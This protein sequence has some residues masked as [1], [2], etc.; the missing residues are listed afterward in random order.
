[1]TVSGGMLGQKMSHGKLCV[2]R[3]PF[4]VGFCFLHP[5]RLLQHGRLN[6]CI[7]SDLFDAG[8][9]DCFCS[10]WCETMQF[11]ST[12]KNNGKQKGK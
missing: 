9:C 4:N 5:S 10:I 8:F 6:Y 11:I 3:D 2:N 1:M 7:G 12:A